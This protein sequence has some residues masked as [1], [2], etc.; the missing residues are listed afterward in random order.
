MATV[1][2]VKLDDISS[3]F[4]TTVQSPINVANNIKSY[5]SSPRSQIS[6]WGM[7]I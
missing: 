6:R 1:T 4:G 3:M 5:S 7:H 2:E